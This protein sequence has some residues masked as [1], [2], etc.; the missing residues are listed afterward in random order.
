MR[1][2]VFY[3]PPTEASHAYSDAE[4]REQVWLPHGLLCVASML[5]RL[6]WESYLVDGRLCADGG[7]Q[8]LGR[9]L[10]DSDVLA[11]TVMTGHTIRWAIDASKIAKDSGAKTIWGGPH[12]T[13]FPMQ[14]LA[15]PVVDYIIIGGRGEKPFESWAHAFNRGNL[16]VAIPGVGF[17]RHGVPSLEQGIN[18]NKSIP[19]RDQNPPPRFD[20]IPDFTPYL[21]NDPA[22]TSKTTNHVT[23]VGCPY[24][25]LFCSEPALSGRLWHAWSAKRSLEEVRRLLDMSGATGVKLH[26]A[27]FFVD[28]RRALSFA[29]GAKSLGIKWAATMHPMTLD[30]IGPAKLEDLRDSGLVRLMIGLESGN[31]FVVDLVDKRFDVTRIPDMANKLREAGIVGMFTFIV[32]FPTAPADEYPDTIR[33]AH[34]IH[35]IWRYHQVK[36]HYASPW[37]GTGM[38]AIASLIP[39]FTAPRKLIEWAEYDYYVPQMIFHDRRWEHEIDEINREYCPYYHAQ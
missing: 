11:C 28:M 18:T 22:V 23:S 6:E 3:Q 19:A 34:A 33:A 29:C 39:N 12:P 37:P 4:G 30:R 9:R 13:L 20:L 10:Q 17:K 1:R 24:S 7:M 8:E 35:K 27:L 36:I 2:I 26:D 5:D 15:D 14:T 31:Q 21:M 25:C 38:W 32:G 16:E